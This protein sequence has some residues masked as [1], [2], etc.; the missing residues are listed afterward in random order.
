ME[1][2]PRYDTVLIDVYL[3]LLDAR[4]DEDPAH[5]MPALYDFLAA[6]GATYRSADEVAAVFLPA[7]GEAWDEAMAA[8]ADG[9]GEPDWSEVFARAISAGGLQPTPQLIAEA[10]WDY[11]LHASQYYQPFPGAVDFLR[12]LRRHSEETGGTFQY[13]LLSNAQSLFTRPELNGSGLQPLVQHA[14][15]SSEIGMRKPSAEFFRYAARGM[16]TEPSR[17]VM[18][19]NSLSDDVPGAKEAGVDVIYLDTEGHPADVDYCAAHGIAAAFAGADYSGVET[20]LADK[21]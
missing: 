6:R 13:A 2:H 7:A 1:K 8:C 10:A 15:L 3:T 11:R 5:A 17:C 20:F 4:V 14:F 18:I 16:R 9:L 19:G 21:I 12:W